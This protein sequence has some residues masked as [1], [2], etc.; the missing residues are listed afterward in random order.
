MEIDIS[1]TREGAALEFAHQGGLMPNESTTETALI[2]VAE[3]VG[4]ALG[5]MA[6]TAK[7]AKSAIMRTASTQKGAK[8]TT[9]RHRT[10]K[11]GA[12]AAHAT[13]KP[14]PSQRKL[15]PARRSRRKARGRSR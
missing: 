4:S 1:A 7:K 13:H 9:N 14:K 11:K 5:S 12:R 15:H 10:P 8:K 2:S 3:S 6:A